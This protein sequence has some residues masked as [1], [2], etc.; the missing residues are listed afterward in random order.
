MYYNAEC[1]GMSA[2]VFSNVLAPT[3]VKHL[4]LTQLSRAIF[5]RVH[6]APAPQ[7]GK[8]VVDLKCAVSLCARHFPTSLTSLASLS[9]K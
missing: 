7:A 2:V 9:F 6:N 1:I 4:L 5:N 8:A 3:V